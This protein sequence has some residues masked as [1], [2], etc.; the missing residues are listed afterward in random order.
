[1]PLT[2]VCRV[3]CCTRGELATRATGLIMALGGAPLLPHIYVYS[4]RLNFNWGMLNGV[5]AAA[6]AKLTEIAF[7][8]VGESV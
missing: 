8:L 6:A 5:A 2:L 7:A 1:M 4:R 3:Y